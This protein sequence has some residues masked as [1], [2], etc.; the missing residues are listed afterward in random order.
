MEENLKILS[1][2]YGLEFIK[3]RDDIELSG[4]PERS[5]TRFALED[6]KGNIFVAEE[7]FK[8][9][10]QRKVDISDILENLKNNGLEKAQI[11]DK[12]LAKDARILY[13]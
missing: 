8:G 5:K 6:K 7:V 3:V 13:L 1:S 11:A 12:V 2:S 10:E 9:L 4:S